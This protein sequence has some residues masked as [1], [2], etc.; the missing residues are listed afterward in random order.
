MTVVGLG[1]G[2][3]AATLGLIY[4]R[5]SGAM[6]FLYSN[7]RIQAR[8]KYLVGE[9]KLDS[10]IEAK[11]LSEFENS[12]QDSE[13]AE[14]LEGEKSLRSLHSKIEKG[15]IESVLELKRTSPEK[16]APVFDAYLMFWEAKVLKT[17]YRMRFIQAQGAAQPEIDEQIVFPVGAVTGAMI[18][19]LSETKTV[20]DMRVVLS[21]TPY[22][23]VFEKD[24]GNIEEFEV[25]LDN[26]V[27]SNFVAMVK[28]LKVHDAEHIIRIFNT[29]FD[30]LNLLVLLKC[31]ARD[32]DED[33]RKR[34]LIGNNTPLFARADKLIHAKGVADLVELCRGTEYHKPLE[35]ALQEYGKDKSLTH[36]EMELYKHH[37]KS[38]LDQE[39]YHVQGPY[40]IFSYLTRKELEQRNL[41]VVSKGIESGFTPK[42]MRE[43]VI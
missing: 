10:L 36:F 30:T 38:V 41:F 3:F 27:Y 23:G 9:A 17:F 24:Y 12:L 19:H 32:I 16:L 7:A 29:K 31:E 43:L 20:A 39:L 34:L 33:K 21:T 15:F 42:E 22:G 13:Y 11:S 2:L 1:S 18:K 35:A 26:V 37:K 14:F 6:T 25:A 8:S 28:K 5:F 40:P 4:W